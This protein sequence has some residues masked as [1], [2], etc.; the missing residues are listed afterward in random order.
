MKFV[1]AWFSLM[2][3]M[4]VVLA[5]LGDKRAGG[6]YGI[7]PWQKLR[8]LAKFRRNTK[9][10][11]TLSDVREHMEL[12]AAILRVPRSVPGDVVECG[13][14]IGGSS[15]NLSLVCELVGRRLIVCDSFEGLPQPGEYDREHVAV[16]VGHVDTY[17]KGR[18]AAPRDA[19]ESN[20]RQYGR[21]D[22]CDIVVGFFDESLPALDR[23]LVMA[24]LDVDLVDSLKPCLAYL[25][26]LL[27]GDSR[28]YVHEAR[29]L[30]LVSIF[31]EEAWWQEHLHTAAPGFVGTGTGLPLGVA[32]AYGSELG[33][34][35]KERPGAGQPVA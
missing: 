16:A 30:A 4:P 21:R 23:P 8:L 18:F 10:I 3:T 2:R 14:Y 9:Q 19:L 28:M 7:G 5:F 32:I 27:A 33:Y 24:F 1:R 31:F 26:P 25:W 17:Y 34:A 35:Q 15:V 11:E 20:L 12:A 29:N 13:C 6:E 22:V